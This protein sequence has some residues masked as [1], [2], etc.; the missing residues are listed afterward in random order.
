MKNTLKQMCI[1]ALGCLVAAFG[2][3]AFLIKNSIAAGGF[4]G[5]AILIN[6]I[7]GLPVG[8]LVFALNIPIFLAA[9][10]ILGRRFVLIS[11]FA[12]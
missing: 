6:S 2:L 10:K 3:N 12:T 11:L 1:I 5:I 9:F 7:T 8:L 4:S